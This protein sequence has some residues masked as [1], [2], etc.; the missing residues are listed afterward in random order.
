ML[1]SNTPTMSP[2]MTVANN[3]P[4]ANHHA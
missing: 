2:A 4:A 1:P 3:R